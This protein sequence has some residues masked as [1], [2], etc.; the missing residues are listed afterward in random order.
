[1]GLELPVGSAVGGNSRWFAP[2]LLLLD[3]MVAPVPHSPVGCSSAMLD[4]G[5]TE[6]PPISGLVDLGLPWSRRHYEQIVFVSWGFVTVLAYCAKL[7]TQK[8]V[9]VFLPYT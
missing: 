2:S 3:A 1:M 4:R 6:V 5:G 8:S 7:R 9:I